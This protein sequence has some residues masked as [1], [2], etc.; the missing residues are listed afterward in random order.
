VEYH[1]ES[2]TTE[3]EAYDELA[4]VVESCLDMKKIYEL[5]EEQE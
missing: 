1:P 5:I 2:V 3:D 4:E